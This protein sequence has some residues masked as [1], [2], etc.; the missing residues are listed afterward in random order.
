MQNETNLN[1]ILVDPA[2][3]VYQKKKDPAMGQPHIDDYFDGLGTS[4]YHINGKYNGT[5]WRDQCLLSF[6]PQSPK[7]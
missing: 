6:L 2:M 3:G 7:P 1:Q 4:I 5:L